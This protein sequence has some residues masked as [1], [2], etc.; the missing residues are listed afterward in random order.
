M[1]ALSSLV[2]AAALAGGGC[3]SVLERT[4]RIA[5]GFNEALDRGV[6]R[7]TSSLYAAAVP[8]F[9]RRRVAGVFDNLAALDTI[10]NDLLQGK[11]AQAGEDTAR[12]VCNTTAGVGGMFDVAAG[13]G[14]E[15]HQEDFGQTLGAWGAGAGPYLVLP[16]F[17]PSSARDAPGIA[18][19]LL[20]S[21]LTWIDEEVGLPL[22]LL[23]TVDRR[24]RA[25]GA[26]DARDASALDP[27]VFTREAYLRR[28]EHLVRDGAPPPG[29]SEQDQDLLEEA[30]RL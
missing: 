12:F 11:L 10:L 5:F 21:P 30:A 7:P 25:Q 24:A 19:S 3:A 15:E 17:G 23:S 29:A 28:R 9:V 13:L 6:L 22:R 26:L 16:L 4:N 20:T 2:L 1:R 8:A 18:V 27:Y 14:L